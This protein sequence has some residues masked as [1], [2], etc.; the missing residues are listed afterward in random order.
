MSVVMEHTIA[1][2]YVLTLMEA[3]L[4]DVIMD[5]YWMLMELLVMVYT[6]CIK[7]IIIERLR[8]RFV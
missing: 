7:H 2:K 1:L 8:A 6:R 5:I 3:S 4:V